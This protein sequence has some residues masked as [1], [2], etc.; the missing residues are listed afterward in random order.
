MTVRRVI[1]WLLIA[2]ALFYLARDLVHLI[3]MGRW[4][5]TPAGKVWYGISPGSLNLLQAGIERHVWKPLWTAIL[6][7]LLRPI[8]VVLGVPGLLL[9]LWPRRAK[10]RRRFGR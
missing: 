2:A 9:A 8:W 4:T 1:G 5:A 7:V 6:W 3:H 10:R